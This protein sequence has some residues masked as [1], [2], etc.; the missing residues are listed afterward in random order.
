MHITIIDV[1]MKIKQ[2]YSPQLF[3]TWHVTRVLVGIPQIHLNLFLQRE[4]YGI[5]AR[6]SGRR[7]DK[8]SRRFDE[9]EVFGIALA[10]ALS[11]SG[12]RAEAVRQVLSDLTETKVASAR[13]AA[14]VLLNAGQR[15]LVVLRELPVPGNE[16]S[17]PRTAVL[18]VEVADWL[19][20]VVQTLSKNPGASAFVLPVGEMFDRIETGIALIRQSS[21]GG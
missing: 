21:K 8:S 3:E 14:G 10:W 13:D 7:G 19:E 17:A 9:E 20:D 4:L 15:Y 12:L 6:A 18:K 16:E 11:K 2:I 1:N 5:T